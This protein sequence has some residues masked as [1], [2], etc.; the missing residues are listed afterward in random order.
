MPMFELNLWKSPGRIPSTIPLTAIAKLPKLQAMISAIGQFDGAR[1]VALI[2][3]LH[4]FL[5]LDE[6]RRHGLQF[7]TSKH[8]ASPRR[9][10]R[11]Q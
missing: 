10:P 5:G 7:E 11:R 4:W 3:S 8:F 1:V 2:E 6:S 9:Q